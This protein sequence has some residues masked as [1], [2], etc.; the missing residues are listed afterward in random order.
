MALIRFEDIV[1][2]GCGLFPRS[3]LRFEKLLERVSGA[4][5]HGSSTTLRTLRLHGNL[6]SS[7]VRRISIEGLE[8]LDTAL[9]QGRGAILWESPF[10]QPVL[11]KAVLAGRGLSLVQVHGHRHGG[12]ESW[13]GQRVVKRIHRRLSRRIFK[14]IIDIEPGS[15]GYL[16]RVEAQLQA[17]RLVCIRA[18]GGSGRKFLSVEFRGATAHLPTGMISL[19]RRIGCPLICLW[20][21]LEDGE[22]RVV[23]W[24]LP[25]GPTG[26]ESLEL[27]AES[28]LAQLAALV[29][30]H[31]EQWWGLPKPPTRSHRVFRSARSKS[32]ESKSGKL[33][34][35]Y[36]LTVD[37]ESPVILEGV[38]QLAATRDEVQRETGTRLPITWFVR[39]Q[40]RW[41]DYR[42]PK[43]PAL[44]PS[45]DAWFD[46]FELLRPLLSDLSS[47]GD[48]FGWHY[49]AYHYVEHPDLPHETRVAVLQ[50]DL[51]ECAEAMRRR[52]PDLRIESFRFGWF[53]VPDHCLYRTLAEV[54]MLVDASA[55]PEYD[56]RVVEQFGIPHTPAIVRDPGTVAGIFC[57]PY[58]RTRLW[59]DWSLVEHDFSWHR[60]NG[61]EALGAQTGF[62]RELRELVA[63]A[64]AQ[65]GSF[66]TYAK[67]RIANLQASP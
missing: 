26:S 48:E 22:Y 8:H 4:A 62:R 54:G 17:N 20:C 27:S 47:G 31:P 45:P 11:A 41:Q 18:M 52:H 16:R 61:R 1:E 9:A 56:G 67:F 29:E 24:K 32:S 51:I 14:E 38:R 23:L 40:R 2:L 12:S 7:Q 63:Q 57:V 30:R 64:R 49:H 60:M 33:P 21:F 35:N 39:F 37:A 34:F 3:T 10:G 59:H 46:G 25:D 15:I 43:L 58:R 28:Y 5:F 53:F 19:S 42:N 13:V 50:A 55:R 66:T 65:G 44:E 36:F 6:S